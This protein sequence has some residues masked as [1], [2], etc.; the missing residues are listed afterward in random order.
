MKKQKFKRPK[1]KNKNK[2]IKS[3]KWDIKKS[4]FIKY[5]PQSK[6]KIQKTKNSN[7]KVN[8]IKSW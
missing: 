6:N 7:F 3:K 4:N 5:H 8:E 2:I 1:Y